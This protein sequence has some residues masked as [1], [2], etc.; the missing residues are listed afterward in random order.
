MADNLTRLAAAGVNIAAGTDAGN[1]LTLHGPSI[2]PE[3]EAMEAAGMAPLDVL[4]AATLGAATAMGR[5]DDL[6]LLQAGRIADLLVLIEDPAQ[7][8]A[9]LRSVTQVMRAGHLQ[10]VEN[11]R[12]R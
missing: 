4:S 3:L 7:G 10:H 9:A 12:P 11:L 6:G 2:F 1:P 8:I 5:G